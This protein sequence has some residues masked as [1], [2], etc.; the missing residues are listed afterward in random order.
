MLLNILRVIA[1]LLLN[2]VQL[3]TIARAARFA[4]R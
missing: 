2:I 3:L 1:H 4:Y